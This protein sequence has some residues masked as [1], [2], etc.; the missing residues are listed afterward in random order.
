MKGSQTVVVCNE[1]ELLEKIKSAHAEGYR[2]VQL[3]CIR[4]GLDMSMNYS[5]DKDYDLVTYRM[6]VDKEKG[7][8]SISAVYPAA[9]L[10]ENEISEQYGFS[11]HGKNLDFNGGLY[12]TAL[13]HA[14]SFDDP[15]AEVLRIREASGSKE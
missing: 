8:P 10:Y 5:F 1:A 7:I 11:I 12:K 3:N 13:K 2:M 6:A 15:K 14:F 4:E 9:Y